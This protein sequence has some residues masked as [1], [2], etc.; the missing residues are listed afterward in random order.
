MWDAH[1]HE[2]SASHF[3]VS[4]KVRS[5]GMVHNRLCGGLPP[6]ADTHPAPPLQAARRNLTPEEMMAEVSGN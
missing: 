4:I 2:P 6:H 3:L 1:S 5:G